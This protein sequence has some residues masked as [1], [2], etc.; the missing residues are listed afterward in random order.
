MSTQFIDQKKASFTLG[1]VRT[2]LPLPKKKK[3]IVINAKYITPL[4]VFFLTL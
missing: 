3:N 1:T 4:I 2:V